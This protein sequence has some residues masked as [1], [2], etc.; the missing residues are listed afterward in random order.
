M[1]PPIAGAR[2]AEKAHAFLRK[3]THHSRDRALHTHLRAALQRCGKAV[4]GDDDD[5]HALPSIRLGKGERE[6][7]TQAASMRRYIKRKRRPCA[8]VHRNALRVGSSDVHGA[9]PPPTARASGEQRRQAIDD[10]GRG[11]DRGVPGP[12][13]GQAEPSTLQ[14]CPRHSIAAPSQGEGQE[15]AHASVA[16]R[17]KGER[18]E[19]GDAGSTL[20]AA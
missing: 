2:V 9:G 15:R 1:A 20:A 17:S 4:V 12:A 6:E 5:P 19:R 14:D 8:N 11:S 10:K 13:S 3:H 7:G 16:T 18:R